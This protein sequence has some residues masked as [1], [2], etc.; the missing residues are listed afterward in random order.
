MKA[1]VTL[2]ALAVPLAPAVADA[3]EDAARPLPTKRLIVFPR[4]GSVVPAKPLKIRV[5][6]NDGATV[7]GTLNGKS[8]FGRFTGPKRIRVMRASPSHGLRHG[9]NVLRLVI[10]RPGQRPRVQT[11]HF[12]VRADRPLAAAGRDRKVALHS[13]LRLNG[14]PSRRPPGAH[15]RLSYRW[16][17]VKAPRTSALANKH[18]RGGSNSHGA[19]NRAGAT[20]SLS[21]RN[22]GAKGTFSQTSSA[23]PVLK[24]D[25]PGTYKAELTVETPNGKL[26]KDEVTLEVEPSPLVKV[27][28]MAERGGKFGVLVGTQFYPDPGAGKQWAQ[29]VALNSK[30]LEVVTNESFD[31]PA[32]TT[33]PYAREKSAV[34]S[35]VNALSSSIAALKKKVKPGQMMT[36]IVASQRPSPGPVQR[37]ATWEAQPPVGLSESLVSIGMTFIPSWTNEGSPMLRGRF[38]VIGNIGGEVGSATYHRNDDL[39]NL[40]DDGSIRG[41]LVS[42]NLGNYSTYASGE[43]L[44]FQTQAPGS[45]A[46]QNVIQIGGSSYTATLPAGSRGGFQVVIAERQGLAAQSYFFDFGS[47]GGPQ[48]RACAPLEELKRITSVLSQAQATPGGA[49]V[50][51]ASVG[52]SRLAGAEP[53]MGANLQTEFDNAAKALVDLIS[54]RFGGTRNAVYRAID[55]GYGAANNSYTLITS[56]GKQAAEG[57]QAEGATVGGLNGVPM[58]GSLTRSNHDYGF[59]LE[60]SAVGGALETPGSLVRDVAYSDPGSWPELGNS[61][62]TAA[63]AQI[64]GQ[65]LGDSARGLFWTQPYS[66]EFWD[67]RVKAIEKLDYNELPAPVKTK[68][69][70]VDYNWAKNELQTEIGWLEA[71]H[72]YI[73]GLARPFA[74]GQLTAWADV[75]EVSSKIGGLI[76]TPPSNKALLI[77]SAVF[78]GV[79]ETAATLVGEV[80]IVGPV[81]ESVNTIYDTVVEITKIA[82][83]T[84]GFDTPYSVSVGEVGKA[85]SERLSKAQATLEDELVDIIAA[86]YRKLKTVGIC[87]SLESACPEG[88]VKNWQ[89]TQKEQDQAAA[90]VGEGVRQSLYATLMPTK[91]EAWR[92]PLSNNRSV[93]WNGHQPAGQTIGGWWCPFHTEPQTAQ[94]SYAV[95]RRIGSPN[96]DGD[97]FQVI[98]YAERTG[99]GGVTNPFN[100]NI[101]AAAVTDPLFKPRSEGGY[102]LSG[103]QF[104]WPNFSNRSPY[105]QTFPLGDS[106]TRWITATDP[107]G[108]KTSSCGY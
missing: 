92:L 44:D 48:C 78:D 38:S 69:T 106:E 100:M 90:S 60:P 33:H 84:E 13:K 27:E 4:E 97:V 58:T 68:F 25:R 7:R 83:E 2:V 28:T 8:G 36:V 77:A 11:V 55:P 18:R 99:N 17:I 67:R 3:A 16:R 31:C 75:A 23:V 73:A 22:L 101:P 42:D 108:I 10:R 52:D 51:I 107:A 79:R 14:R 103:E 54:E 57:V 91:L 34:Q 95:K 12:R 98:A 19:L 105:F 82:Q 66:F 72:A 53:S 62:R 50:T 93:N 74:K 61:G 70:A 96:G 6:A 5:R 89:Y 94:F 59:E 71:A 87:G 20:A 63:V 88:P 9:R 32:A 39:A 29:L 104:Y 56:P 30:N 41:Y 45:T 40:R 86:D 15:G 26:G 43:H 47:L 49:L 35:C 81:V 65:F 85:L 64:A 1:L 37:T 46:T 76:Q 102:G 21:N 80:P 24:T